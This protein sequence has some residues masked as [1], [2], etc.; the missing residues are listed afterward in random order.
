M[1]DTGLAG[2]LSKYTEFSAAEALA[3]PA[4]AAGA[5]MSTGLGAAIGLQ[6][7]NRSGPWGAA[8]GQAAAAPP[9]PPPPAAAAPQWHIAENGTTTGPFAQAALQG[10]RPKGDFW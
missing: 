4:S 5:A 1:Q 7:A 10:R 6:M 9:P 2:D 8:P 3:N